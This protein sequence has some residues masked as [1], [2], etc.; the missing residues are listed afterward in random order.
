MKQ[1]WAQ[2]AIGTDGRRTDQPMVKKQKVGETMKEAISTL[3]I[4]LREVEES[5][6]L[7]TA[8][9]NSVKID[10]ELASKSLAEQQSKRNQLVDAIDTLWKV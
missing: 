6:R 3:Q 5:I 9:V 1:A 2:E 10:Y 4:R 8:K 7:V